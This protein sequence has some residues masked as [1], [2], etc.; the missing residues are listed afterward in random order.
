M[1]L[2]QVQKV[3]TDCQEMSFFDVLQ[4]FGVFYF[5]NDK[6]YKNFAVSS[7]VTTFGRKSHLGV[8]SVAVLELSSVIR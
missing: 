7:L 4:M 2:H 1:D 6:Q 8:H 5:Y 3:E